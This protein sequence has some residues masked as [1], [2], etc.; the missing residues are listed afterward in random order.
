MLLELCN[1][2]LGNNDSLVVRDLTM[3]LLSFAGFLRFDEVLITHFMYPFNTVY[4]RVYCIVCSSRV[5]QMCNKKS[6]MLGLSWQNIEAMFLC[7][8]RP[9]VK[10]IIIRFCS[11][12]TSR[13]NKKQKKDPVSIEMLLELCNMHLGN[14]DLLAVRDLTMILLSFARFLR[15]DEV[16]SL[17]CSDVK[18]ECEYLFLFIRKSKTDQYRNGNE[19][20]IAKGETIACPFSILSYFCKSTCKYL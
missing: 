2:H 17:L 8:S 5:Q 14:N 3:I 12:V 7:E 13:V 4:Y 15:F 10:R 20:L 9:T 1:M 19:V 18:I 16:S 6:N 11:I